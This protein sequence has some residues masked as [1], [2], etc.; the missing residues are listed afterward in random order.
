[1]IPEF[2]NFKEVSFD[3]KDAVESFT[4]KFKPYSDFN[5]IS[6]WA[7][8][9]NGRRRI[10]VLN[11]NL[12][13]LFTDYQ[14]EKPF[15]SFLGN[16]RVEETVEILL[17]YAEKERMPTIL[18]FIGQ[19]TV[20]ALQN[21]QLLIEEDPV[22]FDYVFSTTEHALLQGNKYS[23]KRHLVKKFIQENPNARYEVERLSD[24]AIQEQLISTLRKWGS[25][26]ILNGKD[27]DFKHEE[28]A[29]SRLLKVLR[30]KNS[31][32]ILSYISLN[33]GM[34]G[35]SIDEILPEG[36]A[37]SHFAKA[38]TEYRGIYEFLNQQV[39]HYLQ[40][41]KIAFWNWEQDLGAK[42]L[43]TVKSSYRP[44]TFLKKYKVSKI[45]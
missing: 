31:K 33:Q 17:A 19:E 32:L 36:Y 21:T 9:T 6:L 41:I 15:I 26:K 35:F 43:Q 4:H 27:Y 14:T 16:T 12:V 38:N 39:A 20:N 22:N 25:N 7:W 5:F 23:S 42:S 11:D 29:I 13:V 8:D 10:S 1:M 3:D 28:I 40:D 24:E 2:P 30:N 44:I 18:S 34:L 45:L 37:I